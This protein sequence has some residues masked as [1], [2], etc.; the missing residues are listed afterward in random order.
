LF[1]KA[2]ELAQEATPLEA[3]EVGKVKKIA[4]GLSPLFS[5]QTG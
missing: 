4:A 2:L 1:R 5:A 3:E